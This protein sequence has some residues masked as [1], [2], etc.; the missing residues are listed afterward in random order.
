VDLRLEAVKVLFDTSVLVAA[1]VEAHSAHERALPWLARGRSGKLDAVVSAHTA[2]ETF[3]VLSTM[4]LSPRIGPGLAR[5]L[6]RENVLSVARVVALSA[7]DYA[8]VIDELGDLGVPGGAVY[9]ALIARA[10]VKAQADQ[11]LTLNP[12]DFLRVWPGGAER[13]RTP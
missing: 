8:A 7:R 11:L 9:D 5:Q 1:I 10:A 4:P 12:K 13:I 2:A 6:V 3:A